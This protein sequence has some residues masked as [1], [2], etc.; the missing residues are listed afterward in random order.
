MKKIIYLDNAATTP[1]DAVVLKK[2]LPYFSEKYGNP[3][4]I[5]RLGQETFQA[6]EESR[7]QVADFLNCS[8]E[9]IYFTG[10]A[11]ES[12][13]LAIWGIIEKIISLG[14]AKPHLII[15]AIEHKAVLEICHKLVER[16]MAE[17]TV[18]PINEEGLIELTSLEK[19]IKKNTRL[20]AVM[21][22]NSEIGTVQP[23]ARIGRLI[24]NINKKRKEPIY[25]YT[26]AVQ[27]ANYLDCRVDNLGV[28]GL[29]FS[30]HKIYGP[31]GISA[32]YLRKG[33]PITPMIIGGGHEKGLRSGTEN[34]PGI[35]GLGAAVERI[36]KS[37]G[38]GAQIKKLRDKLITGILRDIPNARFN[39]SLKERL[40]NNAHFSFK[41]AEGE[42]IIIELS[43][44]GICASTGSA[45]ASHSLKPSDILLALGLSHEEA[46]CSVRLTLGK[47]TKPSDID[48]VLEIL[49]G[50]IERLRKISG[51]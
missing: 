36:R 37:G 1:V 18:L 46:H 11:T 48:Y 12:D 15:S 21:Y 31:K 49:P 25:F 13:N 34:V 4:S 27:A 51:R 35:V 50:I 23:I 44:R 45:C 22:A 38:D 17:L 5:H 6:I 14:S 41:G 9:E 26:D 16:K 40:P 2:M 43:Q 39:G 10:S 3:S 7:R 8:P 20:V 32:F 29:S 19:A 24:Q 47:Q 33:T 30:G 28:D 42:S